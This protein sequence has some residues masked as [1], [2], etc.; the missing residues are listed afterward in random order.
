MAQS[1]CCSGENSRENTLLSKIMDLGC[2]QRSI[3]LG[4]FQ[5][6]YPAFKVPL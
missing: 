3:E 6:K 5:G 2:F 4:K 1:F